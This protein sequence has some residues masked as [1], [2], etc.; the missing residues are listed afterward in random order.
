MM[1]PCLT[2]ASALIAVAL[3]TSCRSTE[4]FPPIGDNVASPIDLAVSED[5]QRFYVLNADFDRTYN[6]G[7]ILVLDKNG[8]KLGATEIPRMGRRMVIAGNDMIVTTDFSDGGGSP[9]LLIFDVTLPDTPVQRAELELTCSP[10]NIAFQKGYQHFAVSCLDGQLLLG[11][12]ANDR[13]NT[14]IK[15]VRSFGAAHRAL[16]LDPKRELVLGF[17]AD[18]SQKKLNDVEYKDATRYD[19]NGQEIKGPNGE[20][21]PNEIPDVMEERVRVQANRSQRSPFQFFVYDIAK[22]RSNAPGCTRTEEESCD[23]PMRTSSDPLVA[24]ELRWTYFRLL[25]A[26][27]K[28]DPSEFASDPTYK[29]YRTNFWEAKPDPALT[30]V[31][32][33]SQR[34]SSDKSPYGSNVLKVTIKGELRAGDQDPPATQ[35][36]LGFERIYGFKDK[37][38]KPN[39]FPS[40]FVITEIQGQKTLILNHVRDLSIWS[41]AEQYFSVAGKTLNGQSGAWS[42][43][44]EGSISKTHL[45]TFYQVA[46][47]PDGRVATCSFYGNAVVLLQLTPGTG[48]EEIARIE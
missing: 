38:S 28:P 23:F 48:F 9:K 26:D 32:Y 21:L 42:S 33:L 20:L 19:S 43:E 3:T 46:A 15:K 30:D 40:D 11:T 10:F 2:A 47:M 12:L 37:E 5:G 22:E 6:K 14:T 29:Y 16:Y 1:R 24:K 13:A 45:N 41:K 17:V 27:G 7:S 8:N 39:H 44:I 36:V 34:S 31:F 25:G 35:D 4:K 18:P